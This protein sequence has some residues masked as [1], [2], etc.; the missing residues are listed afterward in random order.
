VTRDISA[1]HLRALVDGARPFSTGV[2]S[3]ALHVL[4]D[5]AAHAVGTTTVTLVDLAECGDD[6]GYAVISIIGSPTAV[7]E[8]LPSGSE[9]TRAIAALERATGRAVRGV[10]P[11]NTAGE[12]AVISLATAAAAS[13]DLVDADGCGRVLPRVEQSLFSLS[14]VP[15][16]PA[17][18]VSPFG[19][20]SVVD[21]PPKRVAAMFPK[22]IAASG[23]WVFFAG[24]PMTGHKLRAL[25][26]P[27]TITRFLDAQPG[28]PLATVPHRIIA[29]TAITA[30]EVSAPAS[31]ARI[32][33]LLRERGGRERLLRADAA[34]EF[35]HVLGD[36]A[37]LAAAPD[38][39]LLVSEAGDVI[40]PDRCAVGMRVD[41]VAVEV[42]AVWREKAN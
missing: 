25:A 12:N 20:T 4:Q 14:G 39:I 7:A 16:S 30:I 27:G 36:G 26:N 5:W 22:L 33:V 19:E 24:Y 34:D 6:D 13:V 40:D 3:S 31:A 18:V 42:P 28:R 23:G 32:S 37:L 21:G 9:P 10:L 1:A 38:E 29:S 15:I 8:N 17:V 35:F 2:N 11:L 41:V